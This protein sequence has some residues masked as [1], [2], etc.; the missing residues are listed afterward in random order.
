MS[1]RAGEKRKFML[2]M[3]GAIFLSVHISISWRVLTVSIDARQE[4]YLNYY[5]Y[6]L[7]GTGHSTREAYEHE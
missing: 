6:V 7:A 2:D 3:F 5:R 4:C 1:N